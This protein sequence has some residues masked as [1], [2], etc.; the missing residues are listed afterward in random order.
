MYKPRIRCYDVSQLSMKFERCVDAEGWYICTLIIQCM[1]NLYL[2]PAVVQFNILSEDYSK[3]FQGR[4]D[5]FD[6]NTT[7]SF[8]VVC[9]VAKQQISGIPC[10]GDKHPFTKTT[11][12]SWY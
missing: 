9:T 8:L 7:L 12:K 6:T 2:L 5:D 10:P 4:M 11:I 1:F 3:V